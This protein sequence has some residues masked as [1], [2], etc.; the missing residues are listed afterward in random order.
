MTPCDCRVTANCHPHRGVAVTVSECHLLPWQ[1]NGSEMAVAVPA[2]KSTTTTPL[3]PYTHRA[4]TEDRT[5][6]TTANEVACLATQPP[7]NQP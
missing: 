5:R 2:R 6:P 4:D 3:C 7:T 1:S